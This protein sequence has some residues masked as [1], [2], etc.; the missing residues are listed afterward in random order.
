MPKH[1]TTTSTLRDNNISVLRSLNLAA[2]YAFGISLFDLY[3]TNLS[4][5]T[6]FL[7]QASNQH[8][9]LSIKNLA[10]TPLNIHYASIVRHN[11]N[12][13]I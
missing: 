5:N 13:P 11:Y 10:T 4:N 12:K 1:N 8:R 7:N 3:I 2:C 6:L 9:K